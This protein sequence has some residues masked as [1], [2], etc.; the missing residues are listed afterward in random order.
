MI[1]K[2]H[3]IN[4]LHLKWLTYIP[5]IAIV[6]QFYFSWFLHVQIRLSII[7]IIIY[8]LILKKKFLNYLN[9]NLTPSPKELKCTPAFYMGLKV[10]DKW[11]SAKRI[12]MWLQPKKKFSSVLCFEIEINLLKIF[13][14]SSKFKEQRQG[15]T[16]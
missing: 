3:E 9:L 15:S 14:Y 5:W 11:Y 1:D 16:V 6:C 10:Y 12:T 8:S 13:K 2:T 4:S 7:R